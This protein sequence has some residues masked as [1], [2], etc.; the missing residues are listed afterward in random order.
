MANVYELNS[1]KELNGGFRMV[2]HNND[3]GNDDKYHTPRAKR[4]SIKKNNK[5]N[6][7]PQQ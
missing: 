7:P 1:D 3:I 5:I 2:D 4:R 6:H